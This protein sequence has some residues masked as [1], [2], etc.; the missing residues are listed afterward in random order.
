LDNTLTIL[1]QVSGE[2]QRVNFF[3]NKNAIT[4]VDSDILAHKKGIESKSD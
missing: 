3:L 4:L 2:D 1:Q